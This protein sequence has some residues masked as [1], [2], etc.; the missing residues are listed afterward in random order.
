M[1]R[2]RKYHNSSSGDKDF[3]EVYNVSRVSLLIT[4]IVG[5]IHDTAILIRSHGVTLHQPLNS[6]LA[7]DDVFVGFIRDF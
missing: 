6:R 5:V 4:P 7:I 1:R 2:L 3:H